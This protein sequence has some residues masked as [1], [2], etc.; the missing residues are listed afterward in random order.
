MPTPTPSTQNLVAIQEIKDNLLFLKDGSL[1]AIIEVSALN[2]ELRSED[3][4]IA[5]TQNFQNFIN[6]IDFPLQISV[7]SR[8]LYIDDYLKFASEATSQLDNELLR[9]QASEYMKFIKE[10][11]S[12]TN[13][14]SKKFYVVVPFYIFETP[15]KTGLFQ[16]F[17]ST[18]NQTSTPGGIAP[19]KFETYKNQIMQRVELVFGGLA[20]LGLK[21][22]L[23]EQEEITKMFYGFYNPE[24]KS[25]EE[26]TNG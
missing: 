22:R 12:L 18:V 17:K 25:V 6:S 11:A 21:T 8:R 10:L 13:I 9:I 26:K 5:I 19:K 1:R 16:S 2:F 14:M 7:I 4:Q 20:G 15:L 3:E 23:L 24:T